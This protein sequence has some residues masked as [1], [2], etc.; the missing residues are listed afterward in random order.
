[1]E[2]R[3]A[4]TQA[5][6]AKDAREAAAKERRKKLVRDANTSGPRIAQQLINA[7]ALRHDKRIAEA[8][9]RREEFG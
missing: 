7:Q 2:E 3:L 5:R 4:F 1:M 8:V 6:E 9:R